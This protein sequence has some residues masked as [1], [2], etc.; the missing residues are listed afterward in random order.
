MNRALL[1]GINKYSF[2]PL[3]GC[4]NDI[5]DMANFLVSKSGFK[6]EDIRLLADERATKD[7]I[8]QRLHWLVKGLQNGDK[9]LFYFSGHG[10][11]LPTRNAKG[12]V[13]GLDEAICP[14]DFDW[15]DAHAIRAKEF[16]KLFSKI[17]KEV[18]FIWISDSCHSG[19][20][21]KS[22][23]TP[24][25]RLKTIV[26]NADINWR[27][28]TAR[29][30]NI[31]PMSMIKA[32]QDTNVALITGCKL[33]QTSADAEFN[34]RP[35]GVLTYFLLEELKSKTGCRISLSKIVKNVQTA[36][37]AAGYTQVPQL[38]GSLKIKASP[39]WTLN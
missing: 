13:N 29:D 17:P 32:V 31:Q 39:F 7:A 4:V 18:E 23:P 14:I 22:M 28:H 3:Q 2:A 37:Y 10:V 15:D 26:P 33:N 20:L 35:N 12:E 24:H 36:L 5:S 30:K 38:E 16:S 8:I 21:W 1:V 6:M 9:V 25:H 19:N 11:Q 34:K 27:L